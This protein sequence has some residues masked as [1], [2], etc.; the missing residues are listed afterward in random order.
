MAVAAGSRMRWRFQLRLSRRE[1]ARQRSA[2]MSASS[3]R[4]NSATSTW[5]TEGT[6]VQPVMDGADRLDPVVRP[7]R[8]RASLPRRRC[9]PAS[10]ACFGRVGGCSSPGGGLPSSACPSHAF[11]A[12]R[13]SAASARAIAAAST[14]AIGLQEHGIGGDEFLRSR[15]VDLE[16]A[17]DHVVHRPDHHVDGALARHGRRAGRAAW[18]RL[19]PR[20]RSLASTGSPA[21]QRLP[22]RALAARWAGWPGRRRRA[23]S[24]R[25]R[26]PGSPACPGGNAGP[27][28]TRC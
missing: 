16:H 26:R 4:R 25:P 9:A 17:E 28:P 19:T 23:S 5:A 15:A 2:R 10:A 12:P 21:L 7:V 20:A 22:G 14:F 13:P 3:A 24:L 11:S 8:A 6:G 27:W 18:K 1:P